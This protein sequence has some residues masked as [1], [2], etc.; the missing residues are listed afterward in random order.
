MKLLRKWQSYVTVG[1]ILSIYLLYAV[2]KV[3]YMSLPDSGLSRGIE[4]KS[5]PAGEA[6]V[7]FYTKTYSITSDGEK[8]YSLTVSSDG[9]NLD[10]LGP[11]LEVYETYTFEALKGHFAI[12]SRKQ[13]D[14]LVI[15]CYDPKVSR[16]EF[17]A[18]NLV[19]HSLKLESNFTLTDV[20]AWTLTPDAL[21]YADETHL[22]R[23]TQ[24]IKTELASS[25][26]AESIAVSTL[27]DGS[28]L[29]GFTQYLDSQYQLDL[30]D[31][32]PSGQVLNYRPSYFVFGAGGAVKPTEL[33]LKVDANEVHVISV[34][35]DQKSGVNIVYWLKSMKSASK[36]HDFKTF[37][38]YT[39]SLSPLFYKDK[40]AQLEVIMTA[41]TS[42]GRV[43]LGSEG[44]FQNLIT[45]D[46]SLALTKSMTKSTKPA[47]NPQWLEVDANHYLF[48]MQTEKSVSHLMVASDKPEL[49]KL[50]QKASVIEMF[51][52]LMTTLTTFLP[53]MYVSLIVEVYVL[54]P[55][56]IA[57]VFISMFKLTW[58]ERHGKEMLVISIALHLL[59]KVYF[60]YQHIIV[61]QELMGNLPNFLD[62]PFK[63]VLWATL[64][65]LLTLGAF[66]AFHKDHPKRHYLQQY[67]FFNL[68]DIVLFTMLY[69][70]YYLL[71]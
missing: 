12:S 52:L 18:L 40:N 11:S 1:V 39:Y 14:Y 2:L 66:R 23:Q 22:I 13:G 53:L 25:T 68:V 34:I 48:Y 37:N 3:D 69:A 61:N 45:T 70:P 38:A 5:Y 65:T 33:E 8:L 64:M 62:S 4:T 55:V 26:F 7:D 20:R 46:S 57:V 63:F 43:E 24:S 54:T 60:I 21:L 10:I 28:Q 9:L 30:I 16:L 59:T 51:N 42:I 27:E 17:Y 35:K 6:F 56:L 47:I 44:S 36:A 67:I 19:D 15:S 29:V 31:L 71:Q 32:S 58:A 50:S 49:I 41:R